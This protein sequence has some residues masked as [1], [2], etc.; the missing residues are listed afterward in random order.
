M[1]RTIDPNDIVTLAQVARLSG[2]CHMGISYH[3]QKGHIE[4]VK[5]GSGPGRW[6]FTPEAVNDFLRK[7][8]Q[9]HFK[10]GRR[11]RKVV[12]E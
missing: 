6:I 4:G 12:S 5:I 3:A 1:N 8:S 9:G 2:I 7:K 10:R 11:P